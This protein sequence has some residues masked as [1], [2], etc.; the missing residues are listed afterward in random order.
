MID[1]AALPPAVIIAIG[2]PAAVLLLLGVS[3]FSGIRLGERLVGNAT[4]VAMAVSLS[5]L[6]SAAVIFALSDRH[7]LRHTILPVAEGQSLTFDLLVDGRSLWF[8][9][10]TVFV[11]M[12]V[13]IFSHRYLHKESG[14][15]RFFVQ[16]N[17]FA[18]GMLLIGM[19][20]ST[21]LLF[22]GWE[23]VGVSSALLVAF[24]QERT[25]PLGNA[26]RVFGVYRLSD[27]AMLS[28]A[29]VAHGT[30]GS[31]SLD[32][33]FFGGGGDFLLS[34]GTATA[35]AVLLVVAAAGK[36]AQLPFSGWLPRSMEGP[37]PS[38][39]V[40]YGALSIHAGA[41]VLLRAGPVLESAPVAQAIVIT[42]GVA[43]A[44]YATIVG[45]VQ[46]DVKSTLAFASLTQV[47]II[48]VEIGLGLYWFALLH[49]TGHALVRLLQFLRAPSVLHDVHE[50]RNAVGRHPDRSG[51]RLELLV[52][53]KWRPAL[54]RFALERGY[55]DA[56]TDRFFIRPLV[57]MGAKL[58]RFE[59]RLCS[60]VARQ[61]TAEHRTGPLPGRPD[62]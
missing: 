46:T 62:D 25:A 2:S 32:V 1:S 33:L 26:L 27:A 28:A 49:M 58:D 12:V 14:Y 40:F 37:T 6:L 44:L 57:T 51:T 54:Y 16:F 22:A 17:L 20:G 43:T 42:L 52:P 29:T 9:V 31:T 15:Y 10:M 7:P 56:G 5:A 55:L 21:T 36:C 60:V 59:R 30:V 48:L 39:A 41:F 53:A 18:I 34:T 47:S 19:A 8:A 38:S 13:A 4:I 35:I 23:F 24:F 45:R 50:T 61:P 11:C 3:A